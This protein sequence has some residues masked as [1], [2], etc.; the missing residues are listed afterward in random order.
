MCEG[1][2]SYYCCENNCS[3]E[4]SREVDYIYNLLR[5]HRLYNNNNMYNVHLYS[6][7]SLHVCK[8]TK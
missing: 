7:Q 8:C 2:L 5:D 4:S 3:E 6:N 1:M